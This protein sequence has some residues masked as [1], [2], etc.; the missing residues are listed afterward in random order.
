MF[1]LSQNV[2]AI[3]PCQ[4]IATA[5]AS[6]VASDLVFFGHVILTEDIDKV[7]ALGLQPYTIKFTVIESYKGFS[8][9]TITLESD[10]FYPYLDFVEGSDYLVY[11]V[12][13]S[14]TLSPLICSDITKDP[15]IVYLS[16]IRAL[17]ITVPSVLEQ[18]SIEEYDWLEKGQGEAIKLAERQ[19]QLQL[20][21]QW[22]VPII[23]VVIIG[24]SIGLFLRHRRKRTTTTNHS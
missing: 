23:L 15:N 11:A 20:L 24:S 22:L 16:K 6:F 21:E 8:N 14:G 13:N 12:N 4:E 9:Q 19:A 5:E 1:V 3:T 17:S 10:G 7:T 2:E 18:E